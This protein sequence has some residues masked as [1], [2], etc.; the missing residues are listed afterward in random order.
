MKGG[1]KRQDVGRRY[2]RVDANPEY[3]KDNLR[4]FARAGVSSN[5]ELV[6]Q[7]DDV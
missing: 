7:T 3:L 6:F 5:I 4:Y 2:R 1:I